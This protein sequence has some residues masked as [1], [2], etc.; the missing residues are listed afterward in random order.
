M[1][2]AL[3][4]QDVDL[5]RDCGVGGFLYPT[6]SRDTLLKSLHLVLEGMCVLPIRLNDKQALVRRSHAE[7]PDSEDSTKSEQS[8]ATIED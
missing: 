2:D 3:T 8:P 1:A 7:A 5:M 6:I 4:V